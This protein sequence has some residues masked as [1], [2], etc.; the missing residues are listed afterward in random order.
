MRNTILASVG[1]MALACWPG[2]SANAQIL[3][4]NCTNESTQIAVWLK[5]AADMAKQLQA[6]QQ[7]YRMLVSTY[8]A[9]SHATDINGVVNALG[10]VT[11]TYIPQASETLGLFGSVTRM[12]GNSQRHMEADRLFS[13][14]MSGLLDR[15]SRWMGRQAGEM[16]RRERVTANVRAL[17]EAG[18]YDAQQRINELE[19][20]EARIRASRD[21]TETAAVQA[22]LQSV[23]M[24]MQAH[25]MQIQNMQ[26]LLLAENRVD[27]QRAEQMQIMGASQWANETRRAVDRLAGAR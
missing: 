7:R 17:A 12:F 14:E 20:A 16:E 3:C 13:Y 27:Q 15:G 26:M 19:A 2:S 10:G 21:G 23:Q 22:A 1:V 9:I 25:Q 24:N 5:Q 4:A 6:A 11:R 8:N 18:M